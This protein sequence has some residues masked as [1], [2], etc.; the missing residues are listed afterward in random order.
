MNRDALITKVTPSDLRAEAEKLI[1]TGKMPRRADG[2]EAIRTVKQ[3][4]DHVAPVVR[5]ALLR[6]EGKKQ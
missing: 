4:P 1:R 2:V 3:N 6:T 5:D